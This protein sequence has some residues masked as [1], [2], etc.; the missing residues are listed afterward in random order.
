[1]ATAE[2]GTIVVDNLGPGPFRLRAVAAGYDNRW[3]GDV[4][5]FENSPD[6]GL[7]DGEE[8]E[9]VDMLLGGQPAT[10]KGVVVGGLVDGASV[11]LIVPAAVTGGINDAVIGNVAVDDTGVFELTNL[12]A[13]GTYTLRVRKTGSITTQ[14]SIQL[15]GGE[16]RSG[17]TVQLRAGDGQ[18]D[19]TIVGPSG[20][21][22]AA[23][24]TITSPELSVATLSLT[25]G[26]VGSFVVPD[27]LTPASYAVSVSLKG[28]ATKSLTISLAS[29]Q[30]V[31]GLTIV[32]EPATGSISGLV[33]DTTGAVLG[34][35]PVSAS[36]GANV[37]STTSV[38]VD[39]PAT[40]SLN[41]IGTFS[42]SNLPAPGIYTLTVGGNGFS[43]VVRNVVLG[44][45][46]LNTQLNV[47]LV[48]STGGVAGRVTDASGP[49]GGVTVKVSS[50]L[51]TRTTTTA[52]SCP[53]NVTDCVGRYRLDGLAPGA[54]TI[55]FSRTGSEPAARQLVIARGLTQTADVVLRPRAGITV[56]VCSS[57]TA[58][59]PT[60]CGSGAKVGYQV[61]LWKESAYPGGTPVGALLTSGNG[62]VTFN[63][64]D[65]PTRYV[66]EV[67]TAAGEAAL[68]SRVV[69]LGASQTLSVGVQI[70]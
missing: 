67:A 61:R 66:I 22:G 28:Y 26:A 54:Y 59:S 2:D 32:L 10:V 58:S 41:E 24:I 16:V 1:M 7:G 19:G 31:N 39:D 20:T 13:P 38:S 70:S 68:T 42:L 47:D 30:Q 35:V 50:G 4:A 3:F 29:G 25:T 55:T 53:P 12:P 34:G 36:D 48:A 21:L 17:I 56:F 65:A 40:A 57:V 44:P 23:A 46:S 62:S 51:V 37:F 18:I 52:S 27:L 64:L 63:N 60:S 14:L 6:V 33:R 43:P 5:A 45:G 8:R 15:A 11:D 49:V 69:S 9:A